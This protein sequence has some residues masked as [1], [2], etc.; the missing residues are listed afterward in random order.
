MREVRELSPEVRDYLRLL[1]VV[2][3]RDRTVERR[4]RALA[5]ASAMPWLEEIRS[6]PGR[7]GPGHKGK[8]LAEFVPGVLDHATRR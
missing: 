4:T 6:R 5:E 8:G 7:S 1:D 3:R 2:L